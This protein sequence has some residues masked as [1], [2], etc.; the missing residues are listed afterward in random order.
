MLK[1]AD[2]STYLLT[3][4]LSINDVIAT[5]S[6]FIQSLCL[7]LLTD[8]SERVNGLQ[9]LNVDTPP[10]NASGSWL[11]TMLSDLLDKSAFISALI[12]DSWADDP[13]KAA[14]IHADILFSLEESIAPLINTLL[15]NFTNLLLPQLVTIVQSNDPSI[16]D[17][18]KKIAHMAEQVKKFPSQNSEI[19][20]QTSLD[21][22]TFGS[23]DSKEDVEEEIVWDMPT[24][25]VS[26]KTGSS[27]FDLPEGNVKQ[28]YDALV[29]STPGTQLNAGKLLVS[30]F[31]A[32]FQTLEKQH[33]ELWDSCNEE[34]TEF[35]VQQPLESVFFDQKI[36]VR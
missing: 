8:V 1:V 34:L 27:F 14:E 7:M 28:D 13:I 24:K 12:G 4:L 25:P 20:P 33:F 11:W 29:R 5:A 6:R 2:V 10:P 16:Q 23:L 35:S 21:E 26:S 19:K 18:V 17:V 22:E 30:T 3:N 15:A 36:L 32:L 9:Q 31:D